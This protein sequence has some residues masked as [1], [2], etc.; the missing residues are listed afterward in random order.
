[1]AK[2]QCSV[3]LPL[4]ECLVRLSQIEGH[5]ENQGKIL[6]KIDLKL[7]GNG[8]A[9]VYTRLDRIEQKEKD[10]K[11]TIRVVIAAIVGLVVYTIKRYI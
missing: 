7:N 4:P 5:L 6:E 1:M 2:E 8:H 11:W 3:P 10:R 9:G